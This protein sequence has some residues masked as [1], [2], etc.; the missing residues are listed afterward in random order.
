MTEAQQNQL[1]ALLKQLKPGFLPYEI[2]EQIARLAALSIIE[3]VPLRMGNDGNVEVLLLER[4][5]DDP[6]WPGQVHTPGTVIRPGDTEG[7]MYKAFER[8]IH[9]E[10]KDTEISDPYYVG[11]LLHES[12]RGTE[13]AQV[14]WVEVLSGPKVGKFYP[15]SNLPVNLVDSQHKFI[16]QAVKSFQSRQ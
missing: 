8:I 2:F 7:T 3:F 11:S 6:I 9:D 13:H 4:E 12:K 10:L 1:V 14:Y 5:A 16:G 15:A